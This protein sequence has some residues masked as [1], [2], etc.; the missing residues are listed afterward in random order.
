MLTLTA[1]MAIQTHHAD[2]IYRGDKQFEYR[3]LR[4]RFTPGIKVYIYEPLPVQ[5]VTGYF[6]VAGLIDLDNNLA[7]LEH[8]ARNNQET[9]KV[10]F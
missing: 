2:R 9:E 8:N 7:E 4:P 3:R 1:V 6:H 10:L 5:A